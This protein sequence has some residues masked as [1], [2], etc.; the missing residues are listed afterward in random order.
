MKTNKLLLA[1]L[2]VSSITT[3]VSCKKQTGQIQVINAT[4]FF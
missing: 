4:V 3:F 1:L 2:G